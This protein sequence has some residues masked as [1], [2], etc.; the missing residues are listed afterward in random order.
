MFQNQNP[1][2]IS[3]KMYIFML[4]HTEWYELRYEYHETWISISI[5]SKFYVNLEGHEYEL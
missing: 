1:R 4:L 2:K 5:L 3:K